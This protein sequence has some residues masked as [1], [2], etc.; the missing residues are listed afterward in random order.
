PELSQKLETLSHQQGATLFMTLLAAFKTLLFRYS[1]QTDLV[2]GS[3]I[4]NRTRPELESLIGFFVNTLPFRSNLSGDPS[5]LALLGQIKQTSQDAYEHQALPFEQLVDAVQPERH[6]SHSPLFQVM[7]IWQNMPQPALSLPELAISSLTVQ[8]PIAKFDL[9]LTMEPTEQGLVGTWEYN[10]AL[11][12]PATI[13]RMS[14]HFQ[15]LLAAITDKPDRS[16][17]QLPLL[18]DPERRQLLLDWNATGSDYPSDQCIHHL[19]EA[20]AERTPDAVAVIYE[21]QHLTYAQLNRRANQLAHYLQSLGA[22]P[23]TLVGICMDRSLEMVTCLLGVLKAGGAYVPL[24]PTHPSERNATILQDAHVLFVIGPSARLIPIQQVTG[25]EQQLSIDLDTISNQLNQIPT[26]NPK[27]PTYPNQ[28]AYTIYTSGSTGRPKGVQ[29]PHQAL[30]NFLLTMQRQPGLQSSDIL[31]SVTTLSFDIAALELYLPLIVGAKVII[32]SQRVTTDGEALGELINASGANVMQATPATWQLL[33]EAGWT[34]HKSFRAL[35]GGEALSLDL[36]RRL[37]VNVRQLWNMYGPTETTIWSSAGQVPADPS[38]IYLGHPLANTPMYI[39]DHQFEPVPIGVSGELYIGGVQVA[40]GYHHR[41]ALTAERFVPNPFGEDRLYKTGDLARYR[42]DGHIE[43]L[44]RVDFQVKIRGYR[45]ELGEIEAVLRHYPAIQNSVVIAREDRG[46]DKRLVAYVVREQPSGALDEE[47]QLFTDDAS[48]TTAL[49][50]FLQTKLPEYMVPT[51]IVVLPTLPLT[52]NGK[53]DRRALPTPEQH[54]PAN[55][56]SPRTPTEMTLAAIWAEVLRVEPVGVEDNFFD[57]GGHSLLATQVV[58]R[59]RH[60]FQIELPLRRLFEQPTIAALAETVTQA[61]QTDL[62]PIEPA[63][64]TQPLPLSFAQQRLWFLDQLEG[65]NATYNLPTA[66]KLTGPVN[67]PALSQALNAIIQRHEVLRTTFHNPAGQAQQIIHDQVSLFLPLVDLQHLSAEKQTRQVTH[68]AEAEALR[69]F[70]LSRDL[71][72]RASLLWLSQTEVVLLLTM[73]HIA[74]DGWSS[75]VLIAEVTALYQAFCQEKVAALPTLPLQYADFAAWQHQPPAQQALAEHLAYWQ[76]RFAQTPPLL[77]LPT[78]H[79]RPPQATYQGAHLSFTLP[80]ELSQKLETLSHQ[81]GA[82]LFMTLLAAFKTLLF[83][84]S[85]Q[86]DLVVGSP[87]ANRTRPELESLIGF[88]VNTLPF[89]SDLSGDPTFLALLDQI[90]QTS[91][92]AYEHQALPFE[93]LVDAV[94]PERHLSH[95]PLFQVMFI[96]QN[97]PQP[98]LSLPG[99]EISPL[100]VQ[101]PIAKFDLTLTMEPTEQGLVGIWEYNTA[102][103]EPATIERMSGHFQTLLAA[104]IDNPDRSIAQLPLLT[105]P[106]RRQLLLDWNATESDYPPDQC[107]HHLFETQAERTPDAIAAVFFDQHVTYAELNS[108]ANQLAHYLQSLGVGPDT[109]VG[110]CLNRSVEMLIGL[111]GILKAGGA[112]VP[113]DPSYPE[114]RLAFMLADAQ[115][116]VL[117][118]G[119]ALQLKVSGLLTNGSHPASHKPMVIYLDTDWPIIAQAAGTPIPGNVADEA[120]AYVIYTSGS[121]GLPKG[122]AMPHYPLVNLLNWQVRQPTFAAGARTLQSTPLSFDVSFQEIFAPWL[123]GGTLVLVPET[124]RQERQRL[125]TFL[126]SHS[127]ERFFLPFVLLQQLAEAVEASGQIPT[128]LTEVIQ[129][130]E[131]L[132]ITPVVAD[133]FHKL[134]ACTLHNH[135]GPTESH[136]VTDFR[137]TGAVHNWPARPSI[138]RPLANVHLFILDKYQEPVPAGIPGE[139][140]IGG[141]CLARGYH[142]RPELT[143]ERFIPNPFASS[144][145]SLIKKNRRD[146]MYKTGDLVRYLSDGNI[147]FLGRIDHQVKLRGFRIELGEIETTL[148]RHPVVLESVV[149]LREDQPDD[150]R[151]VAYVMTNNQNLAVGNASSQ[152]D[153]ELDERLLTAELRQFLQTKLPDYMIPAA[154]VILEAFPVTPSGKVDRKALPASTLSLTGDFVPPRDPLEQKL[155]HIWQAILNLPSISIRD[156]FF[157]LGGHSLLAVQLMVHIQQQFDQHLPLTALFQHPTIEALALLLRQQASLEQWSP[158]A[159]IQPNGSR[160]PFFCVPGVGSDMFYLYHLARSMNT[161]HPFMGLQAKGLDGVTPPYMTIEAIAAYYLEAI[162]QVQPTGPY[163]LGGYSF[164]GKVAFEM[165]QQLLQQGQHVAVL[166]ILDTTPFAEGSEDYAHWNET[167]WLLSFITTVEVFLGQEL[168]VT[169]E[170]LEALSLEE[171]WSTIKH[172]VEQMNILPANTDTKQLR[173][174][175]EVFKANMLASSIYTAREVIP[176]PITLFYPGDDPTAKNEATLK[177]WS[178]I[179][180]VERYE[181]PGTHLTMVVEPHVQVLAEKLA[182]CLNQHD[183]DGDSDKESNQTILKESGLTQL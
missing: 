42:P 6:L 149:V 27:T 12:E 26:T 99:L 37:L 48:L 147:E 44:G 13:A 94:Q 40:R 36:A 124:M 78:D 119:Q 101:F 72:L 35:C 163:Y 63:D 136:V 156:S 41:P 143:R 17:A 126:I 79:P 93:R 151:I 20:Q 91:Q 112:Y 60:H 61:R 52:P 152:N 59:I 23:E 71:M 66:L 168:G 171:Q 14:G 108:R 43:F 64:R 129:C 29:I 134:P 11:F 144:I 174:W 53:V 122:V 81:Q 104:I 125:L 8:F 7:F 47:S 107:I 178:A 148:N 103:F 73:H 142:N 80:P 180:P 182:D 89:R 135:Y 50:R 131:P 172:R 88:F 49:R 67:M 167:Q 19:F 45:I 165:A 139:L 166:A 170:V 113:L 65:A 9:T 77:A 118:T 138:G 115:V 90:K 161:E 83:R 176:L 110:L 4:A 58:S 114:E 120:L 51:A 92:D 183:S 111:L 15:T 164:G 69:P 28:L 123:A 10:T 22:G 106:E 30:T 18:T 31:L 85:G 153:G 133:L 109:L 75:S 140:Y 21:D 33:L 98:A 97:M 54:A 175:V 96:W 57:L 102:L 1:G 145:P 130:G 38:Q 24:D 121:T 55:Y 46:G 68:L 100:T 169:Q 132:K 127:I 87:I 5:F 141:V 86:T 62:P 117:L 173:G 95:S 146:R 56:V 116:P 162:Q 154:V 159:S 181:V 16:I 3:P 2:I 137:L 32:A 105:D 160:P 82:T 25:N 76:N 84:Y 74:A 70:D 128:Q 150:Q 179:G 155:V 157:D 39:L 177:A 158:L 34:E